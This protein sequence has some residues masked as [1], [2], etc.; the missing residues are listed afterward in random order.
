MI[1]INKEYWIL[2]RWKNAGLQLRNNWNEYSN[3]FHLFSL[4]KEYRHSGCDYHLAI[5]GIELRLMIHNKRN[6]K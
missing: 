6:R 3:K 2:Y 4:H 1:N 5:I